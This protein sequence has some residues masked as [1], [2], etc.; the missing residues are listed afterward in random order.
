MLYNIIQIIFTLKLY[1]VQITDIHF[2]NVAEKAVYTK[3]FAIILSTQ[4]K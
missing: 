2:V 4:R 3:T 1:R